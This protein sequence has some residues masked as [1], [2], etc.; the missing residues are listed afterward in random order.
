MAISKR[1]QL[2]VSRTMMQTDSLDEIRS[3][4]SLLHSNVPIMQLQGDDEFAVNAK[5]TLVSDQPYFG[6]YSLYANDVGDLYPE[7]LG[8]DPLNKAHGLI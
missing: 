7:L 6:R 3:C 8:Q 5:G 1:I 2:I 4:E